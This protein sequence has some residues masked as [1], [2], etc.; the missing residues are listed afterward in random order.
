M[1]LNDKIDKAQNE[2]QALDKQGFKAYVFSRK[3]SMSLGVFG[4]SLLVSF[5]FGAF[6]F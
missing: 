6:I 4:I 2:A 1:S 3:V 5:L